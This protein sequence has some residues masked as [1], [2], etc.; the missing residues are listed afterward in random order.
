MIFFFPFLKWWPL[1]GFYFWPFP[2]LTFFLTLG[3]FIF[4]FLYFNDHITPR[5]LSLL[6]SSLLFIAVFWTYTAIFLR[7][8]KLHMYKIEPF[9]I[10][11]F[12][13]LFDGIIVHQL[14]KLNTSTASWV[15][16]SWISHPSCSLFHQFLWIFVSSLCLEFDLL[17][18]PLHFISYWDYYNHPT[19]VWAF[20]FF[21]F[22][23]ILYIVAWLI[24]PKCNW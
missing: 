16:S 13:V 12:F 19:I 17:S 11:I 7:N 6:D 1:L 2:F 4:F 18:L 8:F 3:K 24:F 15:S 22:K 23:A 5:Y 21:S 20:Y 14:F 9:L 10:F